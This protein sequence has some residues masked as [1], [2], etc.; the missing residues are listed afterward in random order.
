MTIYCDTGYFV[1]PSMK[2]FQYCPLLGET[3]IE[4]IT[5]S[6]V[7]QKSIEEVTRRQEASMR[8]AEE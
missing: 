1:F 8:W 2:D 3:F 4:N 7:E 5:P 6:R